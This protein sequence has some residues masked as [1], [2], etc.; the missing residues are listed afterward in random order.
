MTATTA[1][2]ASAAAAALL[3]VAL[4]GCTP[5]EAPTPTGTPAASETPSETPTV[6]P[7]EETVPPVAEIDA[8]ERAAIVA[9]IEAGD[10]AA[11]GPYLTD[12][13]NY[14]LA[15]SECCGV[16]SA[17][18]AT[19]ELIGYTSG[20]SGWSSPVDP[21]YLD[22]VRMSPYYGELVPADVIALRASSDGLVVILG[23]E[24]DRIASVL[25]GHEDVLL[26]T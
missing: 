4:A 2:L 15:S 1:R 6:E 3:L 17:A 19:G 9:G 5:G 20:S 21:A 22:Q 18:D 24:G 23:V 8:S 25:V 26:F 16:I 10:P 14:I 7:A 11:V 12:P 13:V